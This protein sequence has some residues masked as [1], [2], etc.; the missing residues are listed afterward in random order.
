MFSSPDE[1]YQKPIY[2]FDDDA[3]DEDNE[4]EEEEEE[5]V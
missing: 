5:D 4:D 2:R 3:W 1:Y